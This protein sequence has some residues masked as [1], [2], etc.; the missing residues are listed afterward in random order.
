M[1]EAEKRLL[2][3]MNKVDICAEAA[4]KKAVES[5]WRSNDVT[6]TGMNKLVKNGYLSVNTSSVPFG[7]WL[8][9]THIP[10]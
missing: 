5:L 4:I 3:R 2:R 9:Y 1:Y 10:T 7:Y 8:D 6:R